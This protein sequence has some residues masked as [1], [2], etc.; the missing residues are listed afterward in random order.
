MYLY[1]LLFLQHALIHFEPPRKDNLYM[2]IGFQMFHY[3]YVIH[4]A[5]HIATRCVSLHSCFILSW[6]L[7]MQSEINQRVSKF[8]CRSMYRELR[9]EQYAVSN[10]DT[11]P[12][13]P[14][15]LPY[16]SQQNY[17]SPHPIFTYAGRGNRSNGGSVQREW[18]FWNGDKLCK[19][20]GYFIPHRRKE[21]GLAIL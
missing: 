18:E 2:K 14:V 3:W 7:K 5:F 16:P 1:I 20:A 10:F 17:T 9:D 15:D 6:T 4:Y 12:P 13:P 19:M 11:T 8:Y 21:K